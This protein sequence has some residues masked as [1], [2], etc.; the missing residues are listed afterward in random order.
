MG[1]G[2][3]QSWEL[4][5]IYHLAV[6]PQLNPL[7]NYIAHHCIFPFSF[8]F[9]AQLVV[10]YQQEI[11]TCDSNLYTNQHK[12][13]IKRHHGSRNRGILCRHYRLSRSV[14]FI[15]SMSRSSYSTTYKV[16]G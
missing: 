11:S 14:S 6:T 15:I 12:L 10:R 4:K 13:D 9:L 5:D 3:N 16:K 2:G 1:G 7:L 8:L